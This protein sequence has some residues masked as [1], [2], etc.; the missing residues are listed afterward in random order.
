VKSGK[1]RR[2]SLERLEDAIGQRMTR[3]V[4]M[5]L[6][7]IKT[8]D[9]V[10]YNRLRNEFEAKHYGPIDATTLRYRAFAAESKRRDVPGTVPV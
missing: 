4:A 1:D 3:S 10:E 7:H 5:K 8:T 9:P 2:S 6:R